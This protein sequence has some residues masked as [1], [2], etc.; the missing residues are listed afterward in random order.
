M[1]EVGKVQFL[2]AV[3]PSDGS[4]TLLCKLKPVDDK[5]W[6]RNIRH[7]DA[8]LT[9]GPCERRLRTGELTCRK[10]PINLFGVKAACRKFHFVTYTLNFG[11]CT[12]LH[13]YEAVRSRLTACE[14]CNESSHAPAAER[15]WPG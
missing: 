15:D 9:L 2:G 11:W 12:G 10:A 4:A 5:S 13:K 14:K 7:G 8:A 6:T 1:I 3:Q